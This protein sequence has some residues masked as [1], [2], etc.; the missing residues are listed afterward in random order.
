MRR[1]GLGGCLIIG[2]EG[3]VRWGEVDNKGMVVDNEGD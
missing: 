1:G 3:S 2:G